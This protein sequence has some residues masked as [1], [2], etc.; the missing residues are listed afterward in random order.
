MGVLS[1][2]LFDEGGKLR[3]N[4]LAPRV[5]NSGHWSQN[6]GVTSQFTNHIRAITDT[7]PGATDPG[8]SQAWSICSGEHPL[9][10]CSRRRT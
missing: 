7:R 8:R 10:N 3:V 1:I 6:A 9:M 5:H 4:E 2:E